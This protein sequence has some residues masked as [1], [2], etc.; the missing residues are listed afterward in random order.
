M[1]VGIKMCRAPGTSP[2]DPDL[3]TVSS[4]LFRIV[5]TATR[6]QRSA[7]VDVVVRREKEEDHRQMDL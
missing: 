1:P 2:S 6:N 5:S 7:T 4:D 3:I